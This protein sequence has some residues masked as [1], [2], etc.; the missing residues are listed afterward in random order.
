MRRPLSIR[1]MVPLAA[2][3]AVAL[4][5]GGTASGARSADSTEQAVRDLVPRIVRAWESLDITKVDPHYAADADLTFFDIAPLQ[6][7]NWAE[8]RAGVQKAFFEPNRSLKFAV[9]DDLR[10]HH[11]GSLA[12]VTFTFGAD[13]VSK[14]G[15]TSHLDGRWTLVLEQRKGRWVVVHE[16]V[17]VP[18]AG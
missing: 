4:V 2:G 8:Y 18:L 14:Q 16:H 7:A 11:R 17:S 12:W 1:S 10:V 9:K 5:V 6:Y 13:V 3:L 15:A